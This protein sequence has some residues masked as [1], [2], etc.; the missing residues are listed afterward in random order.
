MDV[1]VQCHGVWHSARLAEQ[2]EKRGKLHKL[3]T[4]CSKKHICGERPEKLSEDKVQSIP[5]GYIDSGL[6]RIPWVDADRYRHYTDL[7]FELMAVRKIDNPD[8]FVGWSGTSLK[9]IRKANSQ[10][11]VTVVERGSAHIEYQRDVLEDNFL[12]YSDISE[13]KIRKEKKEYDEADYIAVPSEFAKKTFI[14]KGISEEKIVK[15]SLGADIEEL[16]PKK[17]RGK[18]IDF[19]YVG[20]NNIRKGL[21]YLLR[22]WGETEFSDS[23]LF[24]RA[25]LEENAKDVYLHEK[26]KNVTFIE[27]YVEN[28]ND[29]YH[30]A[31]VLILPS[32]EDGFARVVTEAMACGLPVIVSENT[33]A[34]ELVEDGENGFIIPIKDEEA[35]NNKIRFF[36]E[37]PEEVER[38]AKN[39]RKTA[40]RYTWDRYGDKIVQEY[41]KILEETQ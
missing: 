24:I 30:K 3:L 8:I 9:S 12:G 35:I 6:R 29:L 2:L 17:T 5:M 7:I 31:D 18:D 15:A 34:K 13:R 41:E 36:R 32:L 22:A 28:L 23:E 1:T 20:T 26:G 11:C 16:H 4:K 39:A 10:G 38:M 21:I 37:N 33:G 14:Q 40:E 25:S 19:L 27:D